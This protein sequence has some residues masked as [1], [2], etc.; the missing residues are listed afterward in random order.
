MRKPGL[1]QQEV[2]RNEDIPDNLLFSDS[3]SKQAAADEP[4]A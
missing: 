2:S 4:M 3:A 1:P